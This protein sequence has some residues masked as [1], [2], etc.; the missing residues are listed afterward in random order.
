MSLQS[1]RIAKRYTLSNPRVRHLHL[2]DAFFLRSP[3]QTRERRGVDPL[4]AGKLLEG[5]LPRNMA[6]EILTTSGE[7]WIKSLPVCLCFPIAYNG[8]EYTRVASIGL[9]FAVCQ[10]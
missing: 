3:N 4:S 10:I 8:V 2:P 5:K 6:E 7:L 1:T 9:F